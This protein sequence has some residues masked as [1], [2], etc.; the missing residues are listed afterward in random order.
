MQQSASRT[1][2]LASVLLAGAG[3]VGWY[4]GV[5]PIEQSEARVRAGHREQQGLLATVGRDVPTRP[6]LDATIASLA[7]RAR[8]FA[9]QSEI[10]GEA[11]SVHRRLEDAAGACGVEIQRIEPRPAPRTKEDK[12]GEHAKI[13]AVAFTVEVSGAYGRVA[14]FLS[15]IDERIGLSRVSSVRLIPVAGGDRVAA[16]IETAHYRVDPRAAG[17][18]AAPSSG[19]AKMRPASANAAKGATP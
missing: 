19:A 8:V 16:V 14:A 10:S 5:R 17:P 3:L 7:E 12:K 9:A 11:N 15:E 13:E 4:L 1:G 18:T 2:A 6:H